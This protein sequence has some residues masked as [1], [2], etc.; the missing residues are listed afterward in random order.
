[1]KEVKGMSVKRLNTKDLNTR[2]LNTKDL[3]TKDLSIK[4]L[5]KGLLT[6]K[7]NRRYQ[8]C[9]EKR[10]TTYG[11]WLTAQ[12]KLWR[13]EACDGSGLSSGDFPFGEFVILCAGAGSLAV[14]A[15]RRI[16]HYFRRHPEALLLYGDE[17]RISPDGEYFHPW[18]KPDWSPDF[19]DS[20]FYFGSLTALRR[21]LFER[22]KQA[23]CKTIDFAPESEEQRDGIL[24]YHLWDLDAYEQW[25]HLCVELA[26]G[27][28]R[29]SRSVGH[30]PQILFHCQNEKQQERFGQFSS[31]LRQRAQKRREAFRCPLVSAVIPSRD[32][33]EILEKCIRSL[34]YCTGGKAGERIPLEIIVVDNGSQSE[35][36][37]RVETLAQAV[38]ESEKIPVRCLYEP[39]EFNFSRMCNLGAEAA[40]GEFLLF[41]ND[42]VELCLP[43]CVEELAV[44][45][46]SG[47]VGAVGMKLYYPNSR[48]IQHA[49]ITNLPMG[50]VHKLQFQEDDKID[51]HGI[52]TGYRNVTAVT[53]ACLMVRRDRFAEAGGFC[54]KLRVAFNDVDLCF[55]LHELGYWNVCRNDLYAYHH[56]SLSRG[57]DESEIK[58][59]RLLEER[60]R[61]YERHP[62]MEGSDPFYS[63]HLNREGLDT[64][65]RPGYVTGGNE[66]Q[67]ATAPLKQ[68]SLEG[69]RQDSC[70]MV[71]AEDC[72]DRIFVGFAAV[73][74]DDNACYE[75]E[76]L[77]RQEPSRSPENQA[78]AQGE[79]ETVYGIPVRGQ[80]RPDLEEN[81]PDQVHTALCGYWIKLEEGVVAEGRYRIG[82]AA[83]NR[84]TGLR[85]VNWTNRFVRL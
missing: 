37:L 11:Q 69:F 42:D 14:D 23:A 48:R 4:G 82:A 75:T 57:A 53:A 26:G 38:E 3:N 33:P 72:R 70:L 55:R 28:R 80:Y 34:A 17:D 45:A 46:D 59:E 22:T 79:K 27:R 62:S 77:L 68:K 51:E 9:L 32:Q 18:F 52:N 25:V 35:N 39:M 54:E 74:G 83:R 24:I 20:S 31:F 78:A 60:R 64:G 65:I 81:M 6:E 61:L 44:T 10:R 85:L 76:L 12:E 13:A 58:L 2:D 67:R 29:G 41:L 19:L 71:R 8:R 43:G 84:V 63:P 56:E 66:I 36:R 5:V 30:M 16:G 49:G 47:H 40:A 73:L 7:E 15:P 21:E 1:M 50:P